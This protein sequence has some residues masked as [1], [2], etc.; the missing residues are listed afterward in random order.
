MKTIYAIK[1][2]INGKYLTNIFESNTEKI[3]QLAK[4][5]NDGCY[6]Y[7]NKQIAID[8]AIKLDRIIVEFHN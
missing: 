2:N 8:V 1:S 5:T 4:F 7:N 3:F 6:C